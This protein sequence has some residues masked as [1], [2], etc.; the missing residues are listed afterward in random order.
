MKPKSYISG[1][2]TPGVTLA[3]TLLNHTV[4]MASVDAHIA[5]YT[6]I[7]PDGVSSGPPLIMG[8]TNSLYNEGKPGLSNTFGAAL[9]GVDFNLY[10]A[11]VGIR[12][13]HMHQGTNYRV[14]PP[15]PICPFSSSFF[16]LSVSCRSFL[17]M[18]H[19][20]FSSP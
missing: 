7:W 12:R 1:A 10:C 6:D 3:N 13:V 8:E 9:W 17:H 19:S 2:T 5:E 14:S 16:S 15:P 18:R 11:S 4:T 20:L